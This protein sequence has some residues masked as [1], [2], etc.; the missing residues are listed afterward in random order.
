MGANTGK[1]DATKLV[2]AVLAASERIPEEA[3]QDVRPQWRTEQN[4]EIFAP[5]LQPALDFVGQDTKSASELKKFLVALSRL[6]FNDAVR[7][8]FGAGKAP[9]KGFWGGASR[10]GS[11][12]T[13]R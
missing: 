8:T 5:F 13:E 9:A 10:S 11:S 12:T 6:N 2:A 3:I 7:R 4:R 1:S